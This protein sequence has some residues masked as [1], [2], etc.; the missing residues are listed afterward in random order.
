MKDP[1]SLGVGKRR[2]SA[3]STGGGGYTFE[4]RV[5]VRFLD[6]V[7]SGSPRPE[8]GDRQVVRVAFQQPTLAPFDDLHVLAARESQLIANTSG[9]KY[10]TENARGGIAVPAFPNSTSGLCRARRGLSRQYLR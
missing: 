1:G 8:L 10:E 3:Y 9:E 5:A 4:R 2:A 6:V 7:S